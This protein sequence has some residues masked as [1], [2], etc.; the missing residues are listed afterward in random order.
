MCMGFG[1]PYEPGQRRVSRAY[2]TATGHILEAA[3]E[4]GL[5]SRKLV[6]NI[7]L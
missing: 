7:K 1:R 3:Y 6:V 5:T 4:N 2:E